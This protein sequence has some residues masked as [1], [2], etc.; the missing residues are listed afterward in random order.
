[1]TGYGRL[2]AWRGCVGRERATRWDGP[3]AGARCA[4]PH[5]G[6]HV[7]ACCWAA[8]G[9]AGRARWGAWVGLG[10]AARWA[11]GTRA[12]GEG[13]MAGPRLVAWVQRGER[14][15]GPLV[16][17]PARRKGGGRKKGFYFYLISV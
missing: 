8:V 14:P 15:S 6:L 9:R 13:G 16:A 10:S 5:E 12:R 1:M 7:R 2:D 3:G 11:V 4:G 17:G